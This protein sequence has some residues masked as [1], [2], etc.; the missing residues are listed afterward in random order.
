M[1]SCR[2]LGIM[3]NKDLS[4]TEH[5]INSIVYRAHQRANAIHRCFESRS[6]D[7]LLRA[8]MVYFRPLL[9]HNINTV[10]WS[11]IILYFGY[12]RIIAIFIGLQKLYN[13]RIIQEAQL[14]Q[15]NSASAAHVE[16]G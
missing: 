8:Y 1:S 16:G 5:H 10:I 7:L 9:E 2:D 4:F 11:L 12:N 6:V 13:Y 14:P 15:R 3:I